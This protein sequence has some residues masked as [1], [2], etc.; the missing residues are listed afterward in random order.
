MNALLIMAVLV[1]LVCAGMLV[2]FH[3]LQRRYYELVA[4]AV[5]EVDEI[6]MVESP[7]FVRLGVASDDTESVQPLAIEGSK[8]I[9]VG[10]RSAEFAVVEGLPAGGGAV[11]AWRVEPANAASRVV[12]AD[13]AQRSA[14]FYPAYP[15]AMT[16]LA[17]VSDA[18]GKVT[19][20]GRFETAAVE[21]GR[22]AKLE[23]PWV[24]QGV[25]TLVV[26]VLLLGVV[27]YLANERVLE[28]AV[29]ATLLTAVA[30]FAFG[31][32]RAASSG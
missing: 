10:R 22:T 12:G 3:S 24:G 16:V 30:G 7:T 17:S 5:G 26:T 4:E 23:L 20:E 31:F 19:H 9:A 11:V 21:A 6:R 8:V 14:S 25:G 13:D 15:G 32:S 29:V 18:S 2:Y 27:L 28:G 1:L